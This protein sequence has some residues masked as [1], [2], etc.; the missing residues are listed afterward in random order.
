MKETV[1]LYDVQLETAIKVLGEKDAEITR[2]K[3]QHA[4]YK[5]K[6]QEAIHDVIDD[7]ITNDQFAAVLVGAIDTALRGLED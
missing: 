4:E 6:V 2:L 3:E 7:Q 5:R 1:R